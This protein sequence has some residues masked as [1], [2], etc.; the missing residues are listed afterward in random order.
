MFNACLKIMVIVAI[1]RA[2]IGDVPARW[3]C[4]RRQSADG[5]DSRNA[6]EFHFLEPKSYCLKWISASKTDK[7]L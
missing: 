3:R 4:Q 7:L 5:E 6:D 2:Q 1:E